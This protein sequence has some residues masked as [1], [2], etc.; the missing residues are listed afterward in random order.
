MYETINE[1][2]SSTLLVKQARS[3]NHFLFYVNNI[4]EFFIMSSIIVDDENHRIL[5]ELSEYDS[6]FKYDD[7]Q[8]KSPYAY[9]QNETNFEI[10]DDLRRHKKSHLVNFL[11]KNQNNQKI[12]DAKSNMKKVKVPATK[13]LPKKFKKTDKS[14]QTVCSEISDNKLIF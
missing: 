10:K 3:Y 11:E 12:N 14:M 2:M 4:S 6:I 7:F 1:R 5:N 8:I 9:F 13:V